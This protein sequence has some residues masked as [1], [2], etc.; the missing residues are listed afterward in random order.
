MTLRE[1]YDVVEARDKAKR[2]VELLISGHS[3]Y[4][5]SQMTLVN[6]DEVKQI[7]SGNLYFDYKLQYPLTNGNNKLKTRG[8]D[9]L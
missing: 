5:V 7:N 3:T 8:R 6:H 4:T 1:Q 9:L 2:I